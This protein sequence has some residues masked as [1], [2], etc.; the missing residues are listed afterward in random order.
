MSGEG[1]SQERPFAWSGL[2]LRVP[3]HYRLFRVQGGHRKG[4]LGI[5][6]EE[7]ARLEVAWGRVGRPRFEPER[8]LPAQLVGRHRRRARKAARQRVEHWAHPQFRPLVRLREPEHA[9]DRCMGYAP[10]TGRVVEL[11]LHTGEAA[12]ADAALMRRLAGSLR[13]QQAE[14]PQR[15]AF[16][17]H[18]LTAPAGFVHEDSQLRVGDMALWFR[19][20]DRRPGR[21]SVRLVYPA[22]LAVQRQRM[23]GWMTNLHYEDRIVG[24]NLYCQPGNRR[25]IWTEQ[26]HTQR[27]PARWCDAW[28]RGPVRLIRWRMP[29]WQRHWL[30][31]DEEADR[32]ISVRLADEPARFQ[33]TLDAVLGGLDW[34]DAQNPAFEPG[35][36][37]TARREGG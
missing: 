21:L 31:H 28:L 14:T 13:D 12:E 20:E 32:L 7:S 5:A 22:R 6:E 36:G 27:G 1:L 4:S 34:A 26:T 11:I 33:P 24:Q 19:R 9:V 16:F 35:A 18:R 25:T 3:A 10:D 23:A 29:S 8:A 2:A 37:A 30:I 17:A 15:W